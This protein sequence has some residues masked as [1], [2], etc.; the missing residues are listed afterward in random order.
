MVEHTS[1]SSL[2]QKVLLIPMIAL[3]AF[4]LYQRRFKDA[5]IRKRIATL[6]LTMVVIGAWAAAWIFARYG[7]SD[8]Y[9]LAVAVLAV[10]VVIWQRR[11][12]L[13]YRVLCVQCGKPLSIM[14]ILSYDSNKCEACQP[15]TTEG[16]RS[17]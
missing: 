6:S 10:A 16:D 13:P 8:T 14:R 12:M 5:A 17:R 4:H 3:W 2:L 7:I 15:A 9:L 11:L 1:I